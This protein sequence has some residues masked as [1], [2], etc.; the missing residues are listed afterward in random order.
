MGCE[1]LC[2]WKDPVTQA[3]GCTAGRTAA[4]AAVSFHGQ[5]APSNSVPQGE[6][7]GMEAEEKQDA[8]SWLQCVIMWCTVTGGASSRLSCDAASVFVQTY[9]FDS[10]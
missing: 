1:W 9:L 3:K 6:E 7:T 2:L 10:F 4:Q 5:K 8:V